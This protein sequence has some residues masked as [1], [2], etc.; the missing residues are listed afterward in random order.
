LK[1]AKVARKGFRK[2]TPEE[3]AAWR[4]RHEHFQHLLERRLAQEGATK[5]E[6]LQRLRDAK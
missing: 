3:R 1:E 2:R 5:E 6:V 4:R